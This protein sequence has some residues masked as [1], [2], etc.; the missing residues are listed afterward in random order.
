MPAVAEVGLTV[1]GRWA[2]IS[3]EMVRAF[4]LLGPCQEAREVAS[5]AL[6]AVEL[7][8]VLCSRLKPYWS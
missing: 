6:V 4:C 8:T 1:V 3:A 7:M 5:S 2:C